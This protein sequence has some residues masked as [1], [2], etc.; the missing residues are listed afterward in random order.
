VFPS[1]VIHVK[2]LEQSQLLE[3]QNQHDHYL[4]LSYCWGDGSR[5]LT[6]KDY[7]ETFKQKLPTDHRMPLTFRDAIKTT[8]K[9]DYQYI[10]ID[11]LC[12]IQDGAQDVQT[13]MARM[14]EI[15]HNSDAA[16]FAAK[17]PSTD[18]GLFAQRNRST[19]KPCNV[20]VTTNDGGELEL[21]KIAFASPLYHY[22]NPLSERG[23]V[24]KLPWKLIKGKH[25]FCVLLYRCFK[26]R[27]YQSSV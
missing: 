27:S 26:N 9:L 6:T 15:Y 7:Y 18:S 24:S 20:I 13:E 11:A 4:A 19:N 16:I 21:R 2:E 17:G 8:M 14:G 5:L 23:W 12:I 1:R 3:T 10:W 22:A 25:Q